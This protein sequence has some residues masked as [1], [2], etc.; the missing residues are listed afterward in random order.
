MNDGMEIKASLAELATVRRTLPHEEEPEEFGHASIRRAP[1]PG[2][3]FLARALVLLVAVFTFLA[4]APGGL[5]QSG[6]YPN[7]PIR[8]VVP[9][10]PGGGNDYLGRL[11]AERMTR[12]MGQPVLVENRAG[13]G[14]NIGTDFVAKQ[15]ADG[16]T[17]LITTNGHVI[18]PFMHSKLPFDAI[19]DFDAV[20]MV[21]STALVLVVTP[22]LPANNVQEFILLAKAKAGGVTYASAGKGTPQ[23]LAGELFNQ[24]TGIELLH[25]PYKGAGPAIADLLGGQ[26]QSFFGAINSLLPHIRTGKMRALGVPSAK[27]IAQLPDV[28]TVAE[29]GLPE[30]VVESWFGVL[31][32]AGTPKNIITRLNAEIGKVVHDQ[33]LTR[34]KFTPLGIE[35]L[36][37]TPEQMTEAMKSEMAKWGKVI[38]SAGIKPE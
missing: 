37:S 29:Q 10:P 25:V 20:S 24:L 13:A 27:R 36:A 5:A 18:S 33:A 26:V 3:C 35:P 31:A 7:R 1:N 15:P 8:F 14:G 28:S 17:L 12:S 38:K 11:L 4:H 2:C 23:H 21:A 34:E 30:F 22:S 6:A 9:L 32:A 19:R 16:Y